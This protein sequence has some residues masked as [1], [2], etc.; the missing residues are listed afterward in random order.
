MKEKAQ[1]LGE[2]GITA[3]WL[4]PPTKASS[5]EGNGYVARSRRSDLAQLIDD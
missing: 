1:M 4:P 5:Q 2:M 3:V